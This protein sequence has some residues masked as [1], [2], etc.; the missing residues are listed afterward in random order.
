MKKENNQITIANSIIYRKTQIWKTEQLSLIGITAAQIPIIIVVC[1]RSIIS[2]NE[3]G[4]TLA[5]DKS[6]IAKI[7][8]KLEKNGYLIRT[9]NKKDKRAFD[10]MPT[11]K[12]KEVYPK[13]IKLAN[14]WNEYL[15]DG[16]SKEEIDIL[17]RLLLKAS[18]NATKFLTKKCVY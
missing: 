13:L 6:T 14:V 9:T 1:K 16:M 15:T 8:T 4:E 11:K 10:L 3:L 5:M 12:S 18:S 7:V 2:Q 17:E